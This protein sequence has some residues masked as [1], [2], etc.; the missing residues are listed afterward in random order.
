MT[1]IIAEFLGGFMGVMVI[2]T[3]VWALFW[4]GEEPQILHAAIAYV[5]AATIYGLFGSNGSGWD[6]SGFITYL[7]GA[8]ILGVMLIF[9]RR[10]YQEAD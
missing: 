4:R 6:F 7:P 5:A 1:Y 9:R 8:I 2:Y 10:A 3:I